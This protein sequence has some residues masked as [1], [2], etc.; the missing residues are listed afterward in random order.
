M[1][2]GSLTQGRSGIPM[3][4]SNGPSQVLSAGVM[5]R[6]PSQD[7]TA[8]PAPSM[9]R[10]IIIRPMNHGFVVAVGCQEFAIER[11]STLIRNIEK[12]LENP[13]QTEQKWLA[14]KLEL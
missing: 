10:Q 13:V 12:Y 11:V 9:P 7:A 6:P 1:N 5:E 8:A 2:D 4:E 14:G 3:Q